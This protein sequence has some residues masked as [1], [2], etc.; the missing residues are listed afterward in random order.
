MAQTDSA[1]QRRAFGRTGVDVASFGIGGYHLV[2]SKDRDLVTRIVAMALDAGAN[3]VDTAW[4]YHE[5]LSEELLGYALKGRRHEV[6]LMSKVCTHGRDRALGMR[7]LEDS[8]RRLQTDHLDLWQLHELNFDNDPELAFRPDGGVEALAQAKRE[9]KVRFVGFT[10]H[11]DPSIHL[12]MLS[13]GFAFDAVQMPLSAFDATFRSFERQ[14]LPEVNRLGMAAI[15]MKVM[16]GGGEPLKTG[17]ITAAEGLR[18][19]LSLPATT[20][21]SGMDSLEV[22]EENLAAAKSFAPM[23][24]AEMTELRERVRPYAADGRVE[25]FKTTAKYDGP[26]VREQHGYPPPSG[27][28]L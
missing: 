17:V 24:E 3:F 23:N 9:G 7:M 26:V 13:Y 5:G 2:L 18:Y 1:V 28:P 10:G 11:K 22:A 12:K 19:A 21:L 25:L 27:L 6:F 15:G 4:E 8:L 16:G 14:V 20:I